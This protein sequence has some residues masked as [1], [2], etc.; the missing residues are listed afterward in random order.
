MTA[1]NALGSGNGVQQQ[2]TKYLYGSALNAS[3]Q[4]GVIQPDATDTLSQN[5]T[6]R[7]WTVTTGSDHTSTSYDQLGRVKIATDQR[8]VEHDYLYDAAGRLSFDEVVD[9]G[10]S[11][12]VDGSVL[13]IG[14][15]Y[16]DMGRVEFTTSY[17]NSNGT[18]TP[19]NQVFDSYD[20]WGNLSQEW[21][22][23]PGA[24]DPETTPSIQYTYADG[25]VD[26]VAAYMRLSQTTYPNGRTVNYNYP[27]GV[28]AVMSRLGSITDSNQT[29]DAAYSYL[30]LGTIIREDY[31][32]AGVKLDYDP[33][34]DNS[35]TGFDRFGRVADQLWAQYGDSPATL[36]EYTYA[37]DRAGNV[38]T[39]TNAT[40]AAL[41]DQFSYDAAEPAHRVERRLAAG[42]SR[43]RG[44]S[45]R[46]ATI[47]ERHVQRGQRGDAQRRLFRLR[48]RRQHDHAHLRRHG[49]LRRLESAGRSGQCFRHCREIQ[50]TTAQIAAF[51]L[52]A[53]SPATRRAR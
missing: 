42:A 23:H 30:G 47:S 49:D 45:T 1:Y 18:G 36:D 9:L 2:A 7:V 24:V 33:A 48:R 3:W 32:Q 46:W 21:Q 39:K 50:P 4:T 12:V 37:Y 41:N 35:Y 34:A 16:D 27:S 31:Q 53:T 28:D 20:G 8:G 6:T 26:G 44:R 51:R 17:P 22:S 43:R 11:G 29:V 40:D 15:L 5:S 14:T 10:T 13:S 38:I 19:V 25:A 52:L